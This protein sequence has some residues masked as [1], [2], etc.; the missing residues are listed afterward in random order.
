MNV[1]SPLNSHAVPQT[2]NTLPIRRNT[3]V[4]AA[5]S[6]PS[7]TTKTPVNNPAHLGNHVDTTA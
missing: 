2:A 4:P 1:N 3:E 5:E 7:P 6:I